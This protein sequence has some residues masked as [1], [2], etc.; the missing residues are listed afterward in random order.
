MQT[1]LAAFKLPAE[2]DLV[3]PGDSEANVPPYVLS[4]DII[5]VLK[6][7]LVTGRPLLISGPPGAGKTTLAQAVAH[8]QVWGFLKH[9]LT[10]RSRLEDL[11]AELDHL[12]RLHDAQIAAAFRRGIQREDIERGGL[13]PEWAYLKPG[14]FWW[15]F[16]AESARRKG[17]T[18]AE[19]EALTDFRVPIPPKSLRASGQGVVILLDEIDK[20]EPDLPND[21]L[22]PLDQR[23]FT[24]PDGTEIRV[25]EGVAVLVMITTNGERDL[26]PAFLRRC[27]HLEL[28]SPGEDALRRIAEFHFQTAAHAGKA[29]VFKAV[30]D[31]FLKLADETKDSGRRPPG[32]SEFLDAVRAC[33]ELD[34]TPDSPDWRRVEQATL[35]KQPTP[36]GAA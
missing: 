15:G 35:R 22:E 2:P 10:S 1:P 16:D 11:T 7:A 24:L 14:L 32:T 4:D 12:Q 28:K 6:V 3:W 33:L 30:A 13:M 21:L 23:G 25:P 19:V 34:I 18:R 31:K 26:P 20:A 36:D 27:L 5:T 29:A 8:A 9:T 17:R